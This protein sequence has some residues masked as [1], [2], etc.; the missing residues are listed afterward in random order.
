VEKPTRIRA[1][2]VAELLRRYMWARC[3]CV[4]GEATGEA[5]S[6]LTSRVQWGPCEFDGVRVELHLEPPIVW[7]HNQPEF[8]SAIIERDDTAMLRLND[9]DCWRNYVH[10]NGPMPKD[11]GLQLQ[12]I[13]RG[14]VFPANTP[15]GYRSR[16]PLIGRRQC[17]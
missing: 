13:M 4:D 6:E 17:D 3:R 16:R 7:D 10:C 5:L 14:A 8:F 12:P 11:R 1:E 2:R 9:L 15:S